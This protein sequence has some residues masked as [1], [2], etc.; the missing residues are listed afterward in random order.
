MRHTGTDLN[1][2]PLLINSHYY[3]LFYRIWL[4]YS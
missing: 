4:Q 1:G 3:G 2:E